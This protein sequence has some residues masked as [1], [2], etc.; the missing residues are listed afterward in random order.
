MLAHSSSTSSSGGSSGLPGLRRA[1]V[2]VGDDL[3]D[4]RGE[5][6]LEAALLVGRRAEVGGVPAAVEEPVGAEFGRHRGREHAGVDVG[7]EHGL[8][9]RVDAAS[10]SV[11]P[12]RYRLERVQRLLLVVL[13]E[14][15]LDAACPPGS[16]SMRRPAPSSRRYR[17]L[18]AG[19]AR[20]AWPWR[21]TRSRRRRS[22]EAL[23]RR[24]ADEPFG[25][26]LRALPREASDQRRPA[27][28]RKAGAAGRVVDER[29]RA[30]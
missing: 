12:E 24:A 9:G 14:R 25:D 1:V 21:R 26:P 23:V 30:C 17:R 10:R 19:S 15:S 8:G 22:P 11:V 4:E 29:P 20:A 28:A 5:Q 18:R 7:V 27:D 2:G 3:L 6:R 16:R 13:F